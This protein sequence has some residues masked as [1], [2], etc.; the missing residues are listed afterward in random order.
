MA[1]TGANDQQKS[2]GEVATD[3]WQLVRDYAK[4]ETVDPLKALGRFLALGVV[5]AVLVILGTVFGVMAILRVLQQE[6][7][8]HLTGSWNFLPYVVALLFC[9]VIVG[10][11]ARAITK[12]NRA[13][14]RP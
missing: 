13:E 10:L 1:P 3:L 9:V 11:T 7:D 14:G 5:G 2:T 4:Q 8:V 6:T 12:P